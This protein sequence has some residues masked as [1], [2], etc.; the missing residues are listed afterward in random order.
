MAPLRTQ[1]EEHV[2]GTQYHPEPA[3]CLQTTAHRHQTGRGEQPSPAS[4]PHPLPGEA[5]RHGFVL[6][7]GKLARKAAVYDA[8]QADAPKGG[9][10]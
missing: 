9:A 8:A 2:A 6:L 7:L 4:V 1:K 10:A 3:T 5:E